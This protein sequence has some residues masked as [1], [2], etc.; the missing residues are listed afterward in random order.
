MSSEKF[1][2]QKVHHCFQQCLIGESDVSIDAYLD[3]FRELYKFFSLMGTVF[4]FVSSDVKEKVEILQK[5]RSQKENSEKFETVQ[6][7]MEY[8]QDA[9]LLDKKDYVSGS[10]T[11]LRLHR[12][13][14]FIYVF[15][16]RLGELTEGDAKTNTICQTSYNETLAQFHPWLIRKG[17]VV[18]MYALPTRDHLLEKVCVDAN[19]AIVLLPEMLAVGR[20]VYDRT[21]A[22]YTK[23]DLHGLP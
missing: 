7:M 19:E 14:D 22:L 15:L 1:D 11:L 4:G 6:I 5:L 16:K 12:G 18:A 13:L 23:F 21:Q 20:Q 17:A 2:L 8:E 10:R 9:N 3:A